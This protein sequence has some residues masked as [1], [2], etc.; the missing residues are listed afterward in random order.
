MERGLIVVRLMVV[1]ADGVAAGCSMVK[2][3][4]AITNWPYLLDALVPFFKDTH[5]TRLKYFSL[6][7]WFRRE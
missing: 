2:V 4:T 7:R 3:D 6:I 5:F 1:S